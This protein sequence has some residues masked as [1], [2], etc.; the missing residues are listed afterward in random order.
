M[1]R[2][3]HLLDKEVLSH[4]ASS[5]MCSPVQG[6]SAEQGTLKSPLSRIRL[7]QVELR[8]R[9][10]YFRCPRAIPIAILPTLAGNPSGHFADERSMFT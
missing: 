5:T 9:R 2:N 7:V 1:C 8:E 10:R 6:Q 3:L 4:V